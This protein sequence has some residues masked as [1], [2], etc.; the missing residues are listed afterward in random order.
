MFDLVVTAPNFLII[1]SHVL[2]GLGRI[3]L[4]NRKAHNN[5]CYLRKK[6]LSNTCAFCSNKLRIKG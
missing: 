4:S 5:T 1:D 2:L 3:R 6:Q